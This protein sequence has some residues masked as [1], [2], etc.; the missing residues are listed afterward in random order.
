MLI[1]LHTDPYDSEDCGAQSKLQSLE[2]LDDR[3]SNINNSLNT[4]LIDCE[5]T[6]SLERRT[7]NLDSLKCEECMFLKLGMIKRIAF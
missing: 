3:N 1:S 5:D 2:I 7:D 6:N 4:E